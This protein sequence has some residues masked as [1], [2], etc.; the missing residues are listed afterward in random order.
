MAI[1]PD[2]IRDLAA[3][4]AEKGLLQPILLRPSNGRYEI[5]YGHCR[6]LAHKLLGKVD[7]AAMV[8][9][10]TDTDVAIMRA[11]E[12]IQRADLTFIE[13]AHIYK[14]LHE[15][16]SMS[17]EEIARQM[18][19]S[20]ASIKRRYELLRMPECL[21][22]AI[23]ARK[24]A[25]TVAECL[26]TLVDVS[27]IEYFLSYAVDHGAT[28]DVVRR[29]VS[30]EKQAMKQREM[31]GADQGFHNPLAPSPPVYV[32]CDLCHSAMEIGT[33]RLYRC[34]PGCVAELKRIIEQ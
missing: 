24:I 1:D 16:L 7:M 33:E 32:P 12:N 3:S 20:I 4:I 14:R 31:G 23:H 18:G 26:N 30:E 34:C 28:Y 19:K 11:S 21:I 6:Y 27:R 17:W 5:V 13:E 25:Y 2:Y 9:E 10:M 22:K 8:R 29:W 15:G